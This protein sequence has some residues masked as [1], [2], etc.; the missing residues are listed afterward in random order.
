MPSP[1]AS[2]AFRPCFH[3]LRFGSAR[4]GF[5]DLE[6][7]QRR[8]SLVGSNPTPSA[9]R[10]PQELASSGFARASFR[11]SL[12]RCE[13]QRADESPCVF[14]CP[15]LRVVCRCSVPSVSLPVIHSPRLRRRKPRGRCRPRHSLADLLRPIHVA[16]ALL[17]IGGV[18]TNSKETGYNSGKAKILRHDLKNAPPMGPRYTLAA[19]HK[20]GNWRRHAEGLVENER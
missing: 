11:F 7:R 1:R 17:H 4:W 5:A 12:S 14:A 15:W 18:R 6:N 16:T 13:S 8:K 10:K 9:S 2:G 3:G 19:R 20:S